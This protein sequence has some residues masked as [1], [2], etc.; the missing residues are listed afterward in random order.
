MLSRYETIIWDWNG[1]ILNDIDLCIEI[2]NHLLIENGLK[3]LDRNSYKNVFGFP[4]TSYYERIG[5]DLTKVSM[6]S[7]TNQFIPLYMASV[8]KCKLQEHAESMILKL[9]MDRK[10]Q[11]V[12]TAAH[13]E[14]ALELLTHYNI[15]KYFK[16]VAGLDNHKAE[17]KVSKGKELFKNNEI[18]IEETV[19]IGDTLHDFKVSEELGIKCILITN[20]HQ[21]KEKLKKGVK[22]KAIILDEISQLGKY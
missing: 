14:I 2:A 13:T 9:N 15:I 3:E 4:I 5:I 6:E 20:G 1:T 11:Y 18:S 21:S 22:D 10:N 19:L 17:S 7:L 8:K 16:E 12:L